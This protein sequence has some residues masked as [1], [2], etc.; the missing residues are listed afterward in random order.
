LDRRAR[1][2]EGLEQLRA[3][4]LEET[5]QTIESYRRKAEESPLTKTQKQYLQRKESSLKR[6]QNFDIQRLNPSQNQTQPSHSS[7]ILGVAIGLRVPVTIAVV[8]AET[9]EVLAHRAPKQLLKQTHTVP[10]KKNGQSHRRL[11]EIS[12]YDRFQAHLQDKHCKQH[13]RHNAQTQFGN[14]RL[15]TAKAEEYFNR[16]LAK[17]IVEV[18]QTYQVSCIV[19]PDLKHKRDILNAEIKARAELKYPGNL[20]RQKQYK[21]EFRTTINQWSYKQLCDCIARKANQ[22]GIETV[23][24]KQPPLGKKGISFQ[25]KAR[26]IA[27]DFWEKETKNS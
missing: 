16:L 7:F 2:R 14:N 9:K 24:Q 3:L 27:F 17:A 1:S 12:D 15:K 23:T 21:Q 11:Q 8:N 18:A 22:V 6:L 20:A 13:Q 10:A 26:Q 5:Y 19:L 4:K 25:E